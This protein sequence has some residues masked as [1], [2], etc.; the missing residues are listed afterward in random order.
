MRLRRRMQTTLE[1]HAAAKSTESALSSH[2]QQLH[3]T[4]W[5][6]PRHVTKGNKIFAQMALNCNLEH[7]AI[8]PRSLYEKMG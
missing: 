7:N 3:Y 1:S 8:C 4:R 6:N 5:L 2:A